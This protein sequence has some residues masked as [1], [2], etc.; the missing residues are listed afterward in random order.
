METIRKKICFDKLLSRKNGIMPYI[1]K[2]SDDNSINYVVS[3]ASKGN[4]G[5]FPCDF[6]LVKYYPY[7][8][9][10]T[11]IEIYKKQELYRLRYLDVIS[12]YNDCLNIVKEGKIFKRIQYTSSE[13]TNITCN[14][15]GYTE[16]SIEIGNV[17]WVEYKGD[18]VSKYDSVLFDFSF[19]DNF[20]NNIYI[21]DNSKIDKFNSLK[22]VYE[23]D[24]N[25]IPEEDRAFFRKMVSFVGIDNDGPIYL[26]DY[27]FAINDYDLYKEKENRWNAW[28]TETWRWC[29]SNP[30]HDSNVHG[31]EGDS[32]VDGDVQDRGVQPSTMTWE[33]YVFDIAYN[34][35]VSMEFMY[36]VEKYVIGEIFVPEKYG[37]ENIDGVKVPNMVYYLTYMDYLDWF[38]EY[39]Q[40]LGDNNEIFKEWDDRGGYPMR[41]FL[42]S[43]T[44]KYPI[45]RTEPTEGT[46]IDYAFAVPNVEIGISL[47]DE[48][49][50]ET[51]YVPYEYSIDDE[52]M[53]VDA[54]IPYERG[55]N[56]KIESALTP[57]FKSF[58]GDIIAES[59]LNTLMSDNVYYV[60]D[61]IYGIFNEFES[62]A[63]LFKCIYYSGCS[64]TYKESY[65]SGY[66]VTTW[67]EDGEQVEQ[68]FEPIEMELIGVT[69]V[70]KTKS[71]AY[72]ILDKWKDI[73]Y[74]QMETGETTS[75]SISY[76]NGECTCVSTVTKYYANEKFNCRW[77][78]CVKVTEDEALGIT[79]GDG[80]NIEFN[81][82]PKYRN[83]LLLG[84][85]PDIVESKNNGDYYYFNVK[86][87]N[88]YTDVGG[89]GKSIYSYGEEKALSIPY[90][91]GIA[92]NVET[93]PDG[94]VKYDK[95]CHIE[96]D[97]SANTIDIDY[98]IGATSGNQNNSGIHYRDEFYYAGNEIVNAVVDGCYASEIL[99][100]N[101]DYTNSVL[102]GNDDLHLTR[103]CK[104]SEITGMEIGT[105]WTSGSSLKAYL[106][107][108]NV[109]DNLMEYPKVNV[110]LS[111]NR[112]NAAAW[113]SHFKLSECNSLEDL[114]NNGNNYFNL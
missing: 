79:C 78:E 52:D 29:T 64:T 8:D 56:G 19:L 66:V 82:Q 60:N 94:V 113:E 14:E 49:Y 70:P 88:G 114:E 45:K 35:P 59:K 111:Y 9:E 72:Q 2:D 28:W 93:Y 87:D 44:P 22:S 16:N 13:I 81:K 110:D 91:S 36:D 30:N 65:T 61:D 74:S 86:Y 47:C 50:N 75:S 37:S 10:A 71:N 55:E 98:V 33:R 57:T 48:F 6:V 3:N 7:I 106:F 51:S 90:E 84:C 104:I 102:V 26:N 76:D 43:I 27:I 40:Y 85:I 34:K 100:E 21:F 73:Y 96:R 112:G 4:Y 12:W 23:N 77:C 62:G 17:A 18:S 58:D 11:N 1:K 63:C 105:Q 92:L 108:D 31:D 109:H 53:V 32:V 41:N 69:G 20:K 99:C 103:N 67:Y 68:K 101:V 15:S 89:S 25:N 95:I 39:Q 54:T 42:M 97:L 46:V 83:L 80:E 38:T 107:T 24:I 5:S